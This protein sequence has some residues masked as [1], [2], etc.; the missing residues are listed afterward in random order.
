MQK[1]VEFNEGTR[2]KPSMLDFQF[3]CDEISGGDVTA[4]HLQTSNETPSADLMDR[5]CIQV[6]PMH[7]DSLA[8][9]SSVLSIWRELLPSKWHSESL[10]RLLT[11]VG[12]VVM[13]DDFGKSSEIDALQAILWVSP[14]QQCATITRD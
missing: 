5:V 4:S 14:H 11:D 3:T 7:V 9:Q 1:S 10:H 12:F 6:G 2:L 13:I 8:R